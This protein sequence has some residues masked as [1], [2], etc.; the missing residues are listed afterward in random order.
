MGQYSPPTH[1]PKKMVYRSPISPHHSLHCL[2]L[3]G[4]ELQ[5]Y[6]QSSVSRTPSGYILKTFLYLGSL[7][8]VSVRRV[9]PSRPP[10]HVKVMEPHLQLLANVFFSS[11]ALAP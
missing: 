7:V 8:C 10:E 5:Q 2:R 9:R 11:S 6:I 1:V 4:L 3:M